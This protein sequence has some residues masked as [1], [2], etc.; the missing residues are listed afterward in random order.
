MP[1]FNFFVLH[2]FPT[3]RSSDLTYFLYGLRVSLKS[4]AS[5]IAGAT[6]LSIPVFAV[7]ITFSYLNN[8]TKYCCSLREKNSSTLYYYSNKDRKST[9]LNS[10]HLGISYAVFCL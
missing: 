9:R 6:V 3:R 10:S 8:S 5:T 4:T 7:V 2:S 1:S